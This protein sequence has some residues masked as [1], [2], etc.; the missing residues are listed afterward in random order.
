MV[1]I[2]DNSKAAGVS[3]YRKLNGHTQGRLPHQVNAAEQMPSTEFR[4]Q[5]VANYEEQMQQQRKAQELYE[6][7]TERF[8]PA[9]M[10]MEQA[11]RDRMN[12]PAAPSSTVKMLEALRDLRS[13]TLAG[14][15][16][17]SAIYA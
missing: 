12:N 5:D 8:L 17:A 9:N 14:P 11:V 2:P 4:T 10:A 1:T 16:P 7:R 3:V 6:A 15:I 13:G